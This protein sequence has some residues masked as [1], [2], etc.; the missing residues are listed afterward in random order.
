MNKL[1]GAVS[2]ASNSYGAATGYGTQVKYLVDRMVKHGLDVAVLANYGLEGRIE[3]VKTPA[4]KITQYPRGYKPYS[5]DVLPLWH[6]Q[7]V[8]ESKADRS[9][10]ITLYDVWV[11]QDLTVDCEVLAWTPIDHVSMSPRIGR[12]LVKP[13]VTP[14]AMAPHGARQM[15]EAGIHC[16]YVPH[17]VDTKVFTPTDTIEGVPSRKYLGVDDDAFLVGMVAA[18]KANGILHRKALAENLLAFAEFKRRK[19][20]AQL[21]LHMEPSNAFQGFKIIDLLKSCG[22]SD[23]S[24]VIA[25]SDRL[26]VG[27]SQKDLAG[28]YTAFDVLL[29]PS[30]G[31]GFGVPTVEAQACGTRVIGSNWAATPDLVSED[32][33]LV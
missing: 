6:K 26:R 27:Y 32:G 23:E 31:E 4:G 28:F 19:P 24:V 7:H 22:L 30:Y 17:S 8:A 21:Y 10:I 15:E 25:D 14:V 29:A 18:N 1:K 9:A 13:N 16:E 5:D 2:V 12:V 3:T 33:W 20:D 11:Y